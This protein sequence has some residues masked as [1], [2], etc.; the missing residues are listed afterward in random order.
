MYASF[1]RASETLRASMHSKDVCWLFLYPFGLCKKNLLLRKQKG[2][3][4]ENFYL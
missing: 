4:Y 1:R 3:N 2:Y